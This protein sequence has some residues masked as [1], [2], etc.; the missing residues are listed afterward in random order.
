MAGGA[1][2][3][4][5]RCAELGRKEPCRGVRC[6]SPVRKDLAQA[7]E[8]E[9]RQR[10]A[11]RTSPAHVLQRFTFP[12]PTVSALDICV[13]S[14]SRGRLAPVTSNRGLKPPAVLVRAAVAAVLCCGSH[15]GPPLFQVQTGRRAGGFLKTALPAN[16]G[17]RGENQRSPFTVRC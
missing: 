12:I 2:A 5:L 9:Q 17:V 4:C 6:S 13:S 15:P 1:A 10:R 16:P 3:R 11:L 14:Q 7:G 8:G